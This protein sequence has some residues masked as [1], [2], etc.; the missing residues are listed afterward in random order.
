VKSAAAA[1]KVEAI[2]ALVRQ[3]HTDNIDDPWHTVYLARTAVANGFGPDRAMFVAG[4]K[5]RIAP[6]N[7]VAALARHGE[8]E[9]VTVENSGHSIPIEQPREWRNVV[10]EFLDR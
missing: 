7:Q 2:A 5:D 8:W 1:N 9:C 10:C 3:T 6:P 4:D